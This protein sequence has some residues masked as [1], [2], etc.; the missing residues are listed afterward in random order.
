MH[1]KLEASAEHIAARLE[2][3]AA[4]LKGV[5]EKLE[6]SAEHIAARLEEVA[7]DL[8]GVEARGSEA[9]D[10]ELGGAVEEWRVGREELQASMEART[11]HLATAVQQGQE[12]V[13]TFSTDILN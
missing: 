4:D 9:I 1:E 12:Q 11:N 2:E 5:D 3:V 10:R 6:A 13:R 8:K 7:A